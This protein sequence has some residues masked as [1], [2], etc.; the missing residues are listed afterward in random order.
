[1]DVGR[2]TVWLSVSELLAPA[3]S[4]LG[5]F[6]CSPASTSR[7]PGKLLVYYALF[8]IVAHNV[9]LYL[10]AFYYAVATHQALV[11]LIP[12]GPH[13]LEQ[14]KIQKEQGGLQVLVSETPH[15]GLVYSQCSAYTGRRP[16]LTEGPQD[17][18][19]LLCCEPGVS[20]F[21]SPDRRAFSE[22]ISQ[23]LLWH[24]PD[25]NCS[26]IGCIFGY[27]TLIVRIMLGIVKV[28]ARAICAS[29]AQGSLVM[30]QYAAYR[31]Q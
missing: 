8:D 23:G 3:L 15:G 17:K 22:Y 1:M 11:F 6:L 18:S 20:L 16:P 4:P 31:L 12:C 5:L 19:P 25:S 10:T 7:W 29:Q 14:V 24:R 30:R 28:I 26:G 2:P 21:R 27:N 13:H 9:A